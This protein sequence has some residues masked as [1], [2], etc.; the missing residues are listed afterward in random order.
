MTAFAFGDHMWGYY[1]FTS[2]FLRV[3][4]HAVQ[5]LGCGLL[6]NP[7]PSRSSVISRTLHNYRP[8]APLCTINFVSPTDRWPGCSLLKHCGLCLFSCPAFKQFRWRLQQRPVI[9]T[10][11]CV[12][13]G[14]KIQHKASRWENLKTFWTRPDSCRI[15]YVFLHH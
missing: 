6:E 7:I 9:F 2:L 12:V 13:R 4:K 1:Y 8:H 14:R 10:S 11:R 5:H 15:F 3:S